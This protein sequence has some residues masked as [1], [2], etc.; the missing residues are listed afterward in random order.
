MPQSSLTVRW[1]RGVAAAALVSGAVLFGTAMPASA[2]VNFNG[3]CEAS[4]ACVFDWDYF[5]GPRW[6]Y[7]GTDTNFSNNYYPDTTKYGAGPP[8]NDS[9]EGLHNFGLSCTA[10]FG[11]N[12]GGAS[13]SGWKVRHLPGKGDGLPADR[14]NRVSSLYWEC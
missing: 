9:A 6:D 4:E 5:E 2:N 7:E 12:A 11:Q 10:V 8:L 14:E 3:T 13:A 1:A